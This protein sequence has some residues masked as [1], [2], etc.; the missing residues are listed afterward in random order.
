MRDPRV[1][2]L[3]RILVGYSTEVK[4]GDTCLIEGPSAA[5]PLIAAIYE[6]VLRRAACRSLS[7]SFDG[8][9]A[10]YFKHASDRAARVG[11]AA[12]E[13]GRRGGRLPDRDLG[14]HQHPRALQRRRPSARRCA[15]RRPAS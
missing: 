7:L 12:L 14:R 1:E 11:L 15:A 6:Q 2:N 4:E 9:Q 10:A 5:E 13:L 3:A 8:Q